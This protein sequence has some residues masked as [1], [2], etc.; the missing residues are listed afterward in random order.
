MKTFRAERL[1][2]IRYRVL[3]RVTNWKPII[4]YHSC[5]LTG[6]FTQDD[7]RNNRDDSH[8][9]GACSRKK[10]RYVVW[11]ISFKLF[12]ALPLISSCEE[13]VVT[14][15]LWRCIQQC[16]ADVWIVRALN[17]TSSADNDRINHLNLDTWLN[18]LRVVSEWSAR[19]KLSM[20]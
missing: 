8:T 17:K 20:N 1:Y 18:K 3:D 11:Y 7:L 19:L 15:K 2:S 4:Q 5:T 10:V 12:I 16:D 13:S 9:D 6:R 14:A